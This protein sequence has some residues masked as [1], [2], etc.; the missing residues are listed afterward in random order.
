MQKFFVQFFPY[1]GK[2][3]SE[4]CTKHFGSMTKWLKIIVLNLQINTIVIHID[5]VSMVNLFKLLM[6]QQ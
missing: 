4:N 2:D 6:R 5:M 3:F 1:N